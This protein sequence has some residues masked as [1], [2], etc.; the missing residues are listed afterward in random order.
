MRRRSP[1]AGGLRR[2]ALPA[3]PAGM[4]DIVGNLTLARTQLLAQRNALDTQIAGLERALAA[5]G[6]ARVGWTPAGRVVARG[7]RGRRRAGSLKEYIGRVLQAQRG[8][9]AVKDI[10]SAVVDAGYQSKNK[11]LA[12]SVGIA[13]TQMSEVS[14]IG[15]GLFRM[16]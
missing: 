2:W 8:P 11:T 15:R 14:K 4:P 6:A 3:G 7:R 1:A 10:T 13:L 5:M 9:M 16:R 12:K